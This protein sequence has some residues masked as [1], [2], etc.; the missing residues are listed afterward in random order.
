MWI[1]SPPAVSKAGHF[2]GRVVQTAAQGEG[3][4]GKTPQEGRGEELLAVLMKAMER[5]GMEVF[6]PLF[7]LMPAQ[8]V[9]AVLVSGQKIYGQISRERLAARGA[10]RGE[11]AEVL[12]CG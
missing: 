5:T 11:G 6:V 12:F 7:V 1:F 3:V 10:G 9:M 4:A 2:L 8:G